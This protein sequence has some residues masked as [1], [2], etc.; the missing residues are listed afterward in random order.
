[1]NTR[2]NPCHLKK[3]FFLPEF[4]PEIISKVFCTKKKVSTNNHEGTKKAISSMVV[5]LQKMVQMRWKGRKMIRIT[6]V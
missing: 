5:Q 1:M 2:M 4:D 6:A 3:A